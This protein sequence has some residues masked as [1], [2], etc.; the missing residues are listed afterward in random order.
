[1]KAW[2]IVLYRQRSIQ[3]FIPVS[4]V[5]E[6]TSPLIEVVI[7][8]RERC[9]ADEGFVGQTGHFKFYSEFSSVVL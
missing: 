8:D 4:Q 5:T 3:V 6:L 1:M 7:E 2:I 9:C